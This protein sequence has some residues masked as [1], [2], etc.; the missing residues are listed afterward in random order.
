[1]KEAQK[2][3]IEKVSVRCS[4][5]TPFDSFSAILRLTAQGARPLL[6]RLA[7]ETLRKFRKCLEAELYTSHWRQKLI[8]VRPFFDRQPSCNLAANHPIKT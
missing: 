1:M 2:G 3:M 8:Q 5:L 6:T 7:M 4:E